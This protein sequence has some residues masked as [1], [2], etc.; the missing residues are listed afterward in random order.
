[1]T[2]SRVQKHTKKEVEGTN[3]TETNGP[4]DIK[5][6]NRLKQTNT[7]AQDPRNTP[8][9]AN[10]STARSRNGRH[11]VQAK[12][13][14]LQ[15]P[16]RDVNRYRRR[17]KHSKVPQRTSTGTRAERGTQ[18]NSI[19]IRMKSNDLYHEG[20]SVFLETMRSN[21][22]SICIHF[23]HNCH[24]KLNTHTRRYAGTH[25]RKQKKREGQLAPKTFRGGF[26]RR[27][28]SNVRQGSRLKMS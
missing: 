20:S 13:Q 19:G 5:P 2:C 15:G 8:R 1:M 24:R 27:R 26:S 18:Q 17:N 9:Q 7:C 3:R 22:V 28:S 16:A 14:V 12:K 25:A 11:K 21:R 4:F 10:T 23:S 6:R